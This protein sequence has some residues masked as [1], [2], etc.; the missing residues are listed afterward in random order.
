MNDSLSATAVSG[1]MLE[2][3]QDYP[4][5]DDKL[6]AADSSRLLLPDVTSSIADRKRTV[7]NGDY[8]SQSSPQLLPFGDVQLVLSR[9]RRSRRALLNVGGVRHE[10]MWSALERL[11]RTRLGRLRHVTS[12]DDIYQLCD[13]FR[14]IGS[15]VTGGEEVEFF[16]DRHARSFGSVLNFYR[17]GENR[18]EV[19]A[20]SRR[21]ETASF[22]CS[23]QILSSIVDNK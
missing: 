14:L 20:S 11:P 8:N 15:D 22:S 2:H 1:M 21:S 12:I 23:L 10:I 6:A 9:M 16:F 4:E 18:I 7:S 13:D 17:T 5:E 3:C 19:F